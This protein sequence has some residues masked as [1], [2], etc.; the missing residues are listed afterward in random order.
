MK[1]SGL[2]LEVQELFS[3]KAISD[4][5]AD[6]IE[7]E[8]KIFLATFEEISN[9]IIRPAM[10]E[11][12]SVLAEEDIESKIQNECSLLPHRNSICLHL[13]LS[14]QKNL[15]S[16]NP[17]VHFFAIPSTRQIHICEGNHSNGKKLTKRDTESSTK[18]APKD[19]T[20]D[21]VHMKC[22]VCIK[23]ALMGQQVCHTSS[24]AYD[25]GFQPTPEPWHV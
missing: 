18:Y 3:K 4:K 22:L 16:L 13:D 14:T 17:S 10:E 24:R 20:S 2:F 15:S 12:V 7:K 21:F 9:S 25:F 1:E 5:K 19:I 6:D 8:N 23:E 11:V